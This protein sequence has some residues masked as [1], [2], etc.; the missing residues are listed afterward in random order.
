MRINNLNKGSGAVLLAIIAYSFAPVFIRAALAEE[1][2]SE[3]IATL[4][5]L[6]AVALLAPSALWKKQTRLHLRNISKKDLIVS[7]LGALALAMHFITWVLAVKYTTALAST[8]LISV[9]IIFVAFLAGVLLKEKQS[10]ILLVAVIPAIAGSLLIGG[11][12]LIRLGNSTGVIYALISALGISLYYIAGR[13]ARKNLALNTYT[14]IVYGAGAVFLLIYSLIFANALPVLSFKGILAVLGLVIVCT[15][16]GHSVVNWSLK[17]VDG[18]YVSMMTLLQPLL[19]L[20]WAML[21][22]DEYPSIEIYFGTG[23]ILIGLG[24]YLYIKK[25]QNSREARKA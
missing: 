19:T 20:V 11:A 17:Y 25:R 6:L 12:D 21:F 13:S 9:Q 8:A 18:V 15:F 24:V 3:W 14:I 10:W 22:F 2:S 7:L 23:A 16:L 5:L 1:M 4:R